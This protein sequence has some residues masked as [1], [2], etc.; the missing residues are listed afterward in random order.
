MIS[1]FQ[2]V[3]Y[4]FNAGHVQFEMT[5]PTRM[6]NIDVL[7]IKTDFKQRLNRFV[8]HMSKYHW[9]L[10][11]MFYMYKPR[12]FGQILPPFDGKPQK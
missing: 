1:L 5:I 3:A 10:K 7:A 2:W 6:D 9:N 12:A 11:E 4:D 8:A